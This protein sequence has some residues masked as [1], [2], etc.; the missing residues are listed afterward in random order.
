ML[1]DKDQILMEVKIP[2]AMPLW[3]TSTFSGL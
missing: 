2:G 3:M 1:L